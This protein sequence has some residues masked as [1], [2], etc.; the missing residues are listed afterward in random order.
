M[1]KRKSGYEEMLEDV[2]ETLKHSPDEVNNVLETSGKVISAANDMTKDELALISAYVKADL[3]EFADNYEESKSGPFYLTI[4]DSIWQ[5]LLE[6][7]DR[8][9]VEWVELFED[10]E[11]QGLYEVGEVI[12]LGVLVCDDCG[13][14]TSYNHPTVIIPCIKCGHKGF[15]RQALKP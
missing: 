11:H 9:K 3:K 5:G 1:P 6:I 10:L 14:K 12:G 15:S 13:H 8:T 4:A 7:T 2:I